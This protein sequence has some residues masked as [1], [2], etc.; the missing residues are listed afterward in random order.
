MQPLSVVENPGFR[1]LIKSM[2]PRYE[3]PSRKVLTDKLI[4]EL[5]KRA[6]TNL[7]L[8]LAD[9]DKISV[10]TDAWTSVSNDSYLG[11]TCHFFTTELEVCSI[12]LD[13]LPITTDEKAESLVQLL[14][15]CF[16]SWSIENKVKHIVTDNAANMK[17]MAELIGLMHFPCVAHSLNLVVK[18]SITKCPSKAVHTA[19]EKVKDIVTF[20]H[21]SPKANRILK[22][23]KIDNQEDGEIIPGK[24]IQYVSI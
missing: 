8:L 18:T 3:L 7:K 14:N 24:L 19:I 9:T 16:K 6:K 5:Y 10:T 4:P 11:V 23:M 22:K 12:T 15:D 20:F 21:K 13:V 1:R 17:L 2:D